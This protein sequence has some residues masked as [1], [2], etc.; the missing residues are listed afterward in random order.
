MPTYDYRCEA[1]GQ[2]YEVRHAMALRPETWGEL[3][4]ACALA[5]DASIPDDAPVTK[6]MSAAGVVNSRVLKNPE[7]PACA[8]G[9]CAGNCR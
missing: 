3:R 4:E 5:E 9:G 8:R 2:V 7:A 6:L 1:N